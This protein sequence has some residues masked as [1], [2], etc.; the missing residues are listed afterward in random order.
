MPASACAAFASTRSEMRLMPDTSVTEYIMQ[1][2]DGPTYGRTSPDAT[3]DTITFGTPIGSRRIACVASAVP[4]EPPAETR[5]PRSRRRATKCSNAIAI[6]VTAVPRSPV[7]TARSPRGWWRATSRGC[8]IAG[9]GLP[10]VARST[11]TV[12]KPSFSRQLRR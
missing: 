3:V 8:T 1:M 5:P 9:E 7:N 10:E 6:S 2:S 11:V 4:P 12:R